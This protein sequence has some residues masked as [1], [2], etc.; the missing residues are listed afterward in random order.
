L[1][2]DLI[3][4]FIF[5]FD[6]TLI[7]TDRAF[8]A[9]SQALLEQLQIHLGLPY[10][11]IE[12]AMAETENRLESRFFAYRLDL[13][14]GS[15]GSKLA[16]ILS[17]TDRHNI[18]LIVNAA[19]HACLWPSQSILSM[20]EDSLNAGKN[21][22]IFTGGSPAHT[23]DK[24]RGSELRRY[25]KC[26]FTGDLHPF[27]DGMDSGLIDLADFDDKVNDWAP[28]ISLG[29]NPKSDERG[30]LALLERANIK[31]ERSLMIG[32]NLKHDVK[33]AQ[34]AGLY[35]AQATWWHHDVLAGVTPNMVLERPGSLVIH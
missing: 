3:D 13:L 19:Y 35:T 12:V 4:N 21:L 6:H 10:A 25:F 32:D 7:D 18:G 5:D 29:P 27:E 22:F 17:D 24:L 15:V 1:R 9:Y 31:A 26:V 11:E 34:A 14:A 30:Y 20:L 16:Q 2:L 8:A 33:S 28:L 23:V